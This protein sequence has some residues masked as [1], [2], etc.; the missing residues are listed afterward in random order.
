MY[1]A[2]THDTCS[3]T[4]PHLTHIQSVW[5]HSACETVLSAQEL[6]AIENCSSW[7]GL[8][9]DRSHAGLAAVDNEAVVAEAPL[10][11]EMVSHNV[12]RPHGEE[13]RVC[14][15]FFLFFL[16]SHLSNCA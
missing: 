10:A 7:H 16:V 9:E 8:Q 1:T 11:D 5:Q 6:F 2:P 4:Q 12:A 13:A 3:A 15:V 14:L